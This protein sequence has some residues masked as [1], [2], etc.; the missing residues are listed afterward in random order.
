MAREIQFVDRIPSIRDGEIVI[1][2]CPPRWK[3]IQAST[4]GAV[5][6]VRVGKKAAGRLLDGRT[7]D[8]FPAPSPVPA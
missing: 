7:W 8:E 4:P 2:E 5:P 3:G 6:M 1:V